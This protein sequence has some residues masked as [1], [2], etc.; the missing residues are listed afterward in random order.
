MPMMYL[1]DANGCS[2][3]DAVT[4][5]DGVL[6]TSDRRRCLVVAVGSIA[7]EVGA[8]AYGVTLGELHRQQA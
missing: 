5:E 2:V 4:A 6:D 8:D 3:P 1:P 7:A